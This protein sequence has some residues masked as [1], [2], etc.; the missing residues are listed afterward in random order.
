[1]C[2][3]K[4]AV[5]NRNFLVRK[6]HGEFNWSSGRG[7]EEEKEVTNLRRQRCEATAQVG[8]DR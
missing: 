2:L 8:E 6:S 5:I 7:Q 3:R 4:E 1:M